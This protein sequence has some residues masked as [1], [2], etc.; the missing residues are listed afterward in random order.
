MDSLLIIQQLVER[1]IARLRLFDKMCSNDQE[2]KMIANVVE[3]LKNFKKAFQVLISGSKYPTT[4]LALL[5]RAEIVAA[6]QDLPT[7]CHGDVDETTHATG[8]DS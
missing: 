5:F 7:D 8:S 4:N 2:W 1:C 3:F 6:L